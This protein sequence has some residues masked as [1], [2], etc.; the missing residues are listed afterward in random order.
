MLELHGSP[1]ALAA[2]DPGQPE[3]LLAALL[4]DAQL[5]DRTDAFLAQRHNGSCG[6]V[7][8]SC[9]SACALMGEEALVDCSSTSWWLGSTDA[10]TCLIVAVVSLST[11]K[12]W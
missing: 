6:P 7:P 3:D 11:G 9:R 2:I 4:A 12:A 5:R 8:A 1:G 10:T